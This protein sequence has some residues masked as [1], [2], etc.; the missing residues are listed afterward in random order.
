VRTVGAAALR[1]V[2]QRAQLHGALLAAI[3]KG[4]ALLE[5]AIRAQLS[6]D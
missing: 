6:G 4:D 3:E 1:L 2:P 5:E